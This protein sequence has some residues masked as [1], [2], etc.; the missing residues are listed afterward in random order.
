MAQ[1]FN[2]FIEGI[3]GSGKSTLLL[4]LH[5]RFPDYACYA[6]GDLSTL[7]LAWC[8]YLSE[9]AYQSALLNWPELACDIREKSKQEDGMRIVAYTKI[10]TENLSFYTAMAQHEIYG[11]RRRMEAFRKI[12]LRRF[13]AFQG[14][15]NLFECAFFQ[16]ILEE[17]MLFG[18]YDDG[19]ILSFYKELISALDMRA[20]RLIRLRTPD[21]AQS[22]QA[23]RR[24]RVN[25][26]GE[27]VWYPL[28]LSYLVDSPYGRA[29]G[30][31]G[32]EDVVAHFERRIALEDRITALLPAGRCIEIDSKRY[33]LEGLLALLQ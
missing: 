15:G 7:E 29:H 10:R 19:Q 27:E 8:A 5:E 1:R 2:L 9:D 30:Y 12:V 14:E 26:Q 6:E 24:E 21:V 13:R 28:M 22:V 4:R 18:Q 23:I 20:F 16:N 32:L 11:G 31:K 25:E 3:P 33:D 17:L